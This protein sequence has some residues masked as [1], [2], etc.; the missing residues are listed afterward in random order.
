MLPIPVYSD[1]ISDHIP[2][3][4]NKTTITDRFS[5]LQLFFWSSQKM[6][7]R[8]SFPQSRRDP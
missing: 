5:S 7:L 6:R 4:G 1:G 3:P 2:E 8:V